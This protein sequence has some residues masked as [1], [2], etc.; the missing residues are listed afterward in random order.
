VSTTPA[1]KDKNFEIK[2]FKYFVKN[3]V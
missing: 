3:V 1:K 2:N